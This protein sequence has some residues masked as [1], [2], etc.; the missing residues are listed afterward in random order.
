MTRDVEYAVIVLD[1]M[2]PKLNG[3]EFL[4]AFH[5]TAPKPRS[6]I[7]VITAFD[8]AK[9]AKLEAGHVHAII[10]KPFDVTQLVTMIREVAALWQAQTAPNVQPLLPEFAAGGDVLPAEPTN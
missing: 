8:D 4:E 6:V 1:L 2:M 5:G 10:R 7:F 3:F 9:V